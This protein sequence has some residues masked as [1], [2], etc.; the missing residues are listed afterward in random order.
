MAAKNKILG[1]YTPKQWRDFI[2]ARNFPDDAAKVLNKDLANELL[3]AW[4][5]SYGYDEET[6]LERIIPIAET[7]LDFAR[8]KR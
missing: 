4:L 7:Y 3:D 1:K 6:W 8:N 2:A 5:E